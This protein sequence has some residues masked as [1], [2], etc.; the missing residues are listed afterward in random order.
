MGGYRIYHLVSLLRKEGHTVIISE[1]NLVDGGLSPPPSRVF[2]G[3]KCY[4]VTVTVDKKKEYHGF[5][6][7]PSIATYSGVLDA[8][9]NFHSLSEKE[10]TSLFSETSDDSED[11]ET[12]GDR[13]DMNESLI[14]LANKATDY[15]DVVAVLYEVAKCKGVRVDYHFVHSS[16]YRS[17]VYSWPGQRIL[18]T[19]MY[20]VNMHVSIYDAHPVVLKHSVP[21]P[22]FLPSCT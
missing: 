17:E 8:Y 3:V 4:M 9:K 12:E 14:P 1:A 10:L 13:G 11:G 21:L 19:T 20:I 15:S 18:Y 2:P 7:T 16:N 5:G 22:S 6:P